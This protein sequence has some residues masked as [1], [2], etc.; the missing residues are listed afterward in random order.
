MQVESF[1]RLHR[2]VKNPKMQCKLHKDKRS[3][4]VSMFQVPNSL[5]YVKMAVSHRDRIIISNMSTVQWV[6]SESKIFH[7]SL[8]VCIQL[9]LST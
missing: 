7:T 9:T 2:I 5:T 6:G 8:K 1:I 3:V 4:V